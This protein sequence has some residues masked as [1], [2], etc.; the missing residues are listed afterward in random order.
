MT[1]GK[2]L[3]PGLYFVATPLG[4]A[5]D[6]TLR[7]LDVLAAADVLAAEDT[8]RLRQLM[9]I[10]GIS[11]KGR[12]ILSYHDRNGPQVR[13]KL[14]EALEQGKSVAYASDA[15]SPLVA[16]PGFT[17]ARAAIEAGQAVHSVTGPSAVVAAL[18]VAGLPT[19][20]FTFAG[21][22]PT[23][24]GARRSFLQS[25]SS[26]PGTLVLYESPKRIAATLREAVQ[27]FGTDRPAAMVR[28][29]TKKFEEARRDTL[30]GLA[31]GCQS[32]PP[33]GEIVLLI[34]AASLAPDSGEVERALTEALGEMRVKE[35]ARAVA[36][37]FGLSRREI[38]QQ[39]LALQKDG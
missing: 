3:E 15:G 8:R 12:R 10:H 1:E 5:R 11:L 29:L 34:G 19:D 36:D 17:L 39:A 32:D 28:E 26:A 16:D 9:D 31:E 37:R 13:P 35:A 14:L 25:L 7:A 2:G 20:K 24:P 6:V 23:A 33:R 18:T 27:V 4:N 38:Y 21:F 30:Q 22:P